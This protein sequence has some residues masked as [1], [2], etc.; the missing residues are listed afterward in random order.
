M[1]FTPEQ[2][3]DAKLFQAM[4]MTQFKNSEEY[5][6]VKNALRARRKLLSDQRQTAMNTRGLLEKSLYFTGKEDGVNAFFEEVDNIIATGE[7]V[8]VERE[9]AESFKEE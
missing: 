6:I 5:Q 8:H 4:R 1:E 2:I 7:A 9:M 3:Q